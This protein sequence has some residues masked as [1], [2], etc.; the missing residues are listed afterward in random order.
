M[1]FFS[2]SRGGARHL[3]GLRGDKLHGSDV[4]TALVPSLQ[5]TTPERLLDGEIPR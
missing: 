2:G 4:T 3:D 1:G 5:P